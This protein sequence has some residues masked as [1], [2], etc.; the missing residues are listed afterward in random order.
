MEQ[1]V[2]HGDGDPSTGP[3]HPPLWEATLEAVVA[4]VTP[5]GLSFVRGLFFVLHGI[6]PL[7]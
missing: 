1:L 7:F 3:A 5:G 6:S 4:S 2:R